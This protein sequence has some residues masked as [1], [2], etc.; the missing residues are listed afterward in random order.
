MFTSGRFNRNA[1]KN[2]FITLCVSLFCVLF[3]FVY[4]KFSHGVFSYSMIYAFVYPLIG[5]CFV[6]MI[7]GIFPSLTYPKAFSRYIYNSAIAVYTT[8]SIFKGVI[9]I[10]GSGGNRFIKIYFIS[11]IVL[12]FISISSYIIMLVFPKETRIN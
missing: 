7:F 9:E 5:G 12:A 2:A 4:E 8:G 3:G 11:G 10:Y 1:M 6:W